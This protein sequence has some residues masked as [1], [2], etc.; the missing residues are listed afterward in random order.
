M[1]MLENPFLF[2]VL[3]NIA[4]N[5]VFERLFAPWL[6]KRSLGISEVTIS[7]IFKNIRLLKIDGY[8]YKKVN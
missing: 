3:I 1:S 2:P 5:S 7:L 6:N 8:H 4:N